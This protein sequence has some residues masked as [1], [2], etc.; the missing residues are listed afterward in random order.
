VGVIDEKLGLPSTKAMDSDTES[1]TRSIVPPLPQNV[2]PDT[3]GSSNSPT[4][5]RRPT[6]MKDPPEPLSQPRTSVDFILEPAVS[7]KWTAK[8][9]AKASWA[10]VT[11]WK[12]MLLS[13]QK[14]HTNLA[15][16]ILNNCLYAQY[17]CM[18]RNA[19]LI[20]RQCCTS[21]VQSFL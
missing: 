15:I 7:E 1:T 12:V 19:V 3:A 8:T 9:I 18:G 20:A 4:R 13:L 21:H 2:E 5:S 10:Y 17:H 6:L 14:S 11:T 16:G